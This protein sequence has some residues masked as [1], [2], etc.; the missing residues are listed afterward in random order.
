[1]SG[2]LASDGIIATAGMTIVHFIIILAIP[3]ITPVISY[4]ALSAMS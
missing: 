2:L 1:L 4:S 3:I